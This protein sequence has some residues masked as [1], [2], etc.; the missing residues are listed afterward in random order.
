M[1]KEDTFHSSNSITPTMA[2]VLM[3]IWEITGRNDSDNPATHEAIESFLR[4]RKKSGIR[5]SAVLADLNSL[6]NQKCI[7][8]FK[9]FKTDEAS[10]SAKQGQP[11]I[12]YCFHAEMVTLPKTASILLDLMN[13]KP[14]ETY[15]IDQ[16]M[17][18][19]HIYQKNGWE[20]D[21]IESRIEAAT[22]AGYVVSSKISSNN[23]ALWG[24][25]RIQRERA[26]L[27]LLSNARTKLNG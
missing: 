19:D 17:F 13:F 18:V 6:P 7:E 10:G 8:S 16:N 14:S 26:Y 11:Q 21:F 24:S 12:A 20:K 9:I 4:L 2:E 1:K 23:N 25:V 15:L 22:Q 3:A 5:V 27:V